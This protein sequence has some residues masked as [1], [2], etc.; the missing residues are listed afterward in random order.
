MKEAKKIW[1]TQIWKKYESL[2][3]ALTKKQSKNQDKIKQLWR[4]Y[5]QEN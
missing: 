4:Q 3:E 1:E 2:L 5:L